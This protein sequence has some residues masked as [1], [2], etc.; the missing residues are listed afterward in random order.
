LLV[1][2]FTIAAG[3]VGIVY[4][5]SVTTLRRS[6]FATPSR[7]YAA[8]AVRIGMGLVLILAA[9]VARWPLMLRVFGVM[10]CLQGLSATLMGAEHARVIL[11][12]EAAHS[13]L[14]RVGA[15]VALVTGVLM[16]V[17]VTTRAPDAQRKVSV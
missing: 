9:S 17:A 8:G 2:L 5:D 11:E 1:A 12:W 4:P 3:I 14:S 7:L 15:I 16:A 10:M 6:Y 13:A